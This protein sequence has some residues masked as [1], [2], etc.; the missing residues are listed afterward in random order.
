MR[1][2]PELL[3]DIRN[4][5]PASSREHLNDAIRQ[6]VKTKERGGKVV[7]VT[8][9]GPNL[10]EGVTT[11]IAEL[12]QKNLIDGVIT[13]SAVVAHEMAGTLDRVKRVQIT[14]NLNLPFPEVPLPRGRIF[15]ITNLTPDQRAEMEREFPEGWDFYDEMA[16]QPGPLVIK[17]AGNMAWPMG[18]RTERLAK[19][20]RDVASQFGTSLELLAGLGAS[21]MT[22]IG[23]G[24][25]KNVPVLVSIPQLVGGGAV[26]LAIGDAISLSRRAREIAAMLGNAD[27]IVESAI[28]LSQEI[29]DG[30]FETYTG[31]GIWAAWDRMPTYSLEG[32]TLIRIDLD[33]NLE[34]AWSLEHSN[35]EVQ[36]AVNQGLPKT[37]R[38]GIPFRMEMSGFARL[39]SSIPVTGDIGAVWPLIAQALEEELQTKLDFISAPQESD[40]GKQMR[41][42]I[43]DDVRY[44]DRSETY[45]QAEQKFSRRLPAQKLEPV[46]VERP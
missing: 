36:N 11:Q 29:H 3:R 26:G 34:L 20:I 25:R 12:I 27:V 14:N 16:A 17:A 45:R 1:P 8:G 42:W 32:K 30:P 18:L 23:A 6:I 19:E 43:A 5:L 44:L 22:M 28:A 4:S 21:P 38:T 35:A 24:A 46:S 2:S 10:H 31:H 37:K 40:Y 41:N 39:E 7:V 9:S 33:S 13:S 15:E